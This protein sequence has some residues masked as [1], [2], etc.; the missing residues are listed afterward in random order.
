VI[1]EIEK[2]MFEMYNLFCY[3]CILHKTVPKIIKNFGLTK[4]MEMCYN[5]KAVAGGEKFPGATGYYKFSWK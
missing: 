5:N 3:L 1:F 4:D 2:I